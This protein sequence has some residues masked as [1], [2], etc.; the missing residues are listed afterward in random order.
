MVKWEDMLN[1]LVVRSHLVDDDRQ[2]I[3]CSIFS[4]S[5]LKH[6][7]QLPKSLRLL[8]TNTN[9]EHYIFPMRNKKLGDVLGRKHKRLVQ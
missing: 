5:V 8:I 2:L 1:E 7:P 3:K 4:A 9:D 6:F